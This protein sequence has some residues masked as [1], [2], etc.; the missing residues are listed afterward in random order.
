M[1][2]YNDVKPWSIRAPS[3]TLK[4]KF[5]VGAGSLVAALYIGTGD[6]NLGVTFGADYGFRMLWSYWVLAIVA[7]AMI[8]MTVR[9]F[10]ATG[11]T[12]MSVFKDLHWS[13]VIYMFLAVM[14][15][16]VMGPWS[17][18]GTISL[19]VTGVFP[20]LPYELAGGLVAL[21]ALVVVWVGVY[22][23]IEKFFL[24]ALAALIFGFFASAI[25]AGI[26]WGQVA[27]GVI[28]QAPGPRWIPYFQA[29]SG[30][31]INSWMIIVFPYTMMEKGLWSDR[32]ERKV[33]ILAQSRWDYG[34]GA[35]AAGVVAIPILAASAAVAKPFGVMP[36]SYMDLAV[37]LEPIAGTA[38]TWWFLFGL[39]AA[40]F[41]TG[42]GQLLITGWA[43]SDF[44]NLPK[45]MGERSNKI[46]IT[47]ILIPGV[48]LLFLRINPVYVSLVF[49]S[50]IAVSF[51]VL[52]I[53]LVYRISRADMGYF[54]WYPKSVR[55]FLLILV[56]LFALAIT[57]W[58]GWVKVGA[59]LGLRG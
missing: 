36:R 25:L 28:P 8:D 50:V 19:V 38:S 21:L 42:V 13:L 43:F 44:F 5:A 9:Y 55:G 33:S 41:T 20:F 54:R 30:S 3:L 10:L 40:C 45:R 57:V 39:F 23:K 22:D 37:L 59:W 56:D 15:M 32:L 29:N 16:S 58:L 7:W 53:A 17:Q 6:V 2:N 46:V 48:L 18:W 12:P 11:K 47:L 4:Q 51:P 27:F 14:M 31:I 26:D 24:I 34:W 52:G 1:A 49:S 35:I